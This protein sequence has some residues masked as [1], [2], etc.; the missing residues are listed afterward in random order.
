MQLFKSGSVHQESSSCWAEPLLKGCVV[1]LIKTNAC[2][3]GGCFQMLCLFFVY[4]TF[5][6]SFKND[7][8]LD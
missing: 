5:K 1:P 8:E 3:Q 6:L 7:N 4:S 2:T